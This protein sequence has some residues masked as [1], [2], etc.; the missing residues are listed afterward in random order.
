LALELASK[1]INVNAVA[2]GA[3]NTPGASNSN[4]ESIK[5]TVAA[6]PWKRMG[7]PDDI[8]QA[9]VYLASPGLI[10]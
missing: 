5:Q 8:A 1:K 10:M 3:I 7:T 4:E 6:I 9:V 2:P